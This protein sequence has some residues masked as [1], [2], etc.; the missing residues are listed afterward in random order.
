MG[1]VDKFAT[2][3]RSCDEDC[4]MVRIVSGEFYG[5]PFYG[6]SLAVSRGA[7]LDFR[8]ALSRD[9]AYFYSVDAVHSFYLTSYAKNG[10]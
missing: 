4:R 2:S 9:F 10:G 6:Q 7:Y 3:R 5:R 1:L 8:E